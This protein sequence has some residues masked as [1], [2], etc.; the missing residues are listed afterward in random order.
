MRLLNTATLSLETFQAQPPRYAI[1]SHRWTEDELLLEHVVQDGWKDVVLSSGAIKVK[2]AC[3]QARKDELHYIWVDTCCIDKS[4]SAELSEAI[5]S[6][7]L[8]YHEAAVCY[9]YLADVT[10]TASGMDG[11]EKSLW[12]SRGW[13]LQELIAPE[14]LD[15]YDSNWKYLGTRN[16]MANLIS[17]ITRIHVQVLAR[18]QPIAADAEELMQWQRHHSRDF[19]LRS[20]LSSY[21]VAARLSWAAGR[22][23]TRIE[24]IAYS[25]LGL[26]DVNMPLLYGEGEK[27]FQRLLQEIIKGT[28]DPSVLVSWGVGAPLRQDPSHYERSSNVRWLEIRGRAS[29]TVSLLNPRTLTIEAL[30]TPCMIQEGGFSYRDDKLVIAVIDCIFDDSRSRIGI[31]LRRRGNGDIYEQNREFPFLVLKPFGKD[32]VHGFARGSAGAKGKSY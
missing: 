30:T 8:W 12:F 1:L 11:F 2:R 31:A 13:T 15:F 18:E 24:D 25:L 27:A 6:M 19:R 10:K 16:K 4:S 23:T 22:V 26:F 7:F 29:S 14:T 32:V 5:N 3:Q 17:R 21:S 28:G 20:I 9:V